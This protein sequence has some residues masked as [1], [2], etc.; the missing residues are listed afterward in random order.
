LNVLPL[1]A[2]GRTFFAIGLLGLGVEH[3]VFQE[4]VTGRAPAWPDGVPGKLLW[5]N[6]AGVLVILAGAAVV[7]RRRG[8]EAMLGLALMV[9]VWALLRHLPIVAADALLAGSWTRA[10][11][12]LTFIGGALAVAG[13]LP[14]IPG[15]TGSAL[16][17]YANATGPF[18]RFG[19]ICLGCFLIIGGLQH[20]KFTAFVAAL[21][22]AW[23]PGNATWWTRFAGVALIAGGVGLIVRRTAVL[24]GL[25]AG[26]MIFSW[27]WIVHVPRTF[28]S[29]SDG[30]AVFE[31]LAFSGI[32][33]VVAGARGE[34]RVSA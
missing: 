25:M 8:S 34:F 4:F 12:A 9:F 24:A 32:G 3:I 10:G 7:V 17:R 19:G 26:L 6:G 28:T 20:F 13:T 5:V 16:R 23:F 27:F 2:I 18:V 1:V 21:I 30:I 15:G 22:P 11:K 14:S 33:L 31:A 29:V